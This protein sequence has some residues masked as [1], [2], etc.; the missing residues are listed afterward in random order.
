[1]DFELSPT[2]ADLSAE[3]TAVG[4]AAAARRRHREDGWLVGH[5]PAFALELAERGWLGM[6]WPTSVGGGGRS[7]LERFVVFEALIAE[8]APVATS[9]FADRQI[10]PTLLQFATTEQR[11]R[12]LPGIRAGTS[13]WCIG[14]SEPD[15]GSD[16]AS[17]RTRATPDPAVPG[18]W[19][20]TGTKLWTSGAASADWC[21]LIARTDPDARPHAGLSELVVDMGS[22]G[23]GVRRIVDP[24]G[25]DHFCEVTFDDV[26]VPGDHLIGEPNGSF[27]QVMRQMEHE[28]GGIDRLVS[29]RRLYLDCLPF[30]DTADARVRQ[31][32]AALETAYR[33]GRL[34]VLREVLG[35]A[36]PAFSAATKTFCTEHEQRVAAFCGRVLGPAAQA[37][38][39]A[40][41]AGGADLR[42]RVARGLAYA[43]AY[44]LM[45]GT[46]QILR[47]ILGERS[48]GLPRA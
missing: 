17:L 1:M 10:G 6:T 46:T 13:M 40:H 22:P 32:I 45:G 25:D 27:R 18:G 43:P 26:A 34:L 39:R 41:P 19:R 3:A 30:A 20:V 48:L 36:P 44:T 16:V 7:P 23:I 33:L 12:W 8:G 38:D 2:L 14:M 15:A 21:Y 35:Q 31:E 42:E 28:R 29:N 9:Y 24:T 37:W 5:D 47:T 11:Q 4:R